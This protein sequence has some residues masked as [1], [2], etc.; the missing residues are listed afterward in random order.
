MG[1]L[2]SLCNSVIVLS[3]IRC[4]LFLSFLC[5]PSRVLLEFKLDRCCQIYLWCTVAMLIK[6]VLANE[7]IRRVV[8]KW[9]GLQAS[10]LRPETQ[11]ALESKVSV[12]IKTK[13]AILALYS[14]N[15]ASQLT[16]SRRS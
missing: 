2:S 1:M 3:G 13:H 7:V 16:P 5:P 12:G 4:A 8:H 9:F 14:S 11:S 6:L 10:G 15:C